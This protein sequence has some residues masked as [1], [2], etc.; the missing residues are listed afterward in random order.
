MLPPHARWHRNS[1]APSSSVDFYLHGA[2]GLSGYRRTKSSDENTVESQ[3]PGLILGAGYDLGAFGVY[4][5]YLIGASQQPK[6]NGA[7]GVDG[8]SWKFKVM[9]FGVAFTSR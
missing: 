5:N 7:D 3:G 6:L 8:Q 2:A 4:A 1:T 9:Q